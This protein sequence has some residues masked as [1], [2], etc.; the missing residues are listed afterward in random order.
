[1]IAKEQGAAFPLKPS[2]ALQIGLDFDPPVL[3]EDIPYCK[4][5]SSHSRLAGVALSKP[6]PL[7]LKIFF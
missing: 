5:K 3:N 6:T 7:S 2:N 1:V 4:K